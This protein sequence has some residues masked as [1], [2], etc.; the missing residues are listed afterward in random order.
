M[1]KEFQVF[2]IVDGANKDESVCFITRDEEGHLR[3]NVRNFWGKPLTSKTAESFNVDDFVGSLMQHNGTAVVEC[4]RNITV[5]FRNWGLQ[6][7]HPVAGNIFSA[8]YNGSKDVT[9]GV[10]F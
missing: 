4:D 2:E 9:G 10:W 6:L 7:F 8:R 3:I 5:V 1:K